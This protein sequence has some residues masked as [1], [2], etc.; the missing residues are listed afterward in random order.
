MSQK[1][2]DVGL[3]GAFRA[4]QS[5]AIVSLCVPRDACV[6]DVRVALADYGRAHWPQFSET[7]LRASAFA[8]ETALLNESDALP[9]GTLAVLP[10]VAGG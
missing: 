4:Y 6:A 7:L 9:C 8:S 10:P 2:I 5:L 3:F 1:T